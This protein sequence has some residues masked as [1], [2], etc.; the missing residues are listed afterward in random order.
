MGSHQLWASSA[1]TVETPLPVVLGRQ[2][3]NAN[4]QSPAVFATGTCTGRA[5]GYG[6]A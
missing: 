2:A 5:A 6:K 4:S 3:M 1:T